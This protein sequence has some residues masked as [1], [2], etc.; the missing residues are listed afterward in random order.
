MSFRVPVILLTVGAGAKW[1][2]GGNLLRLE[3]GRETGADLARQ[4]LRAQQQPKLGLTAHG[5]AQL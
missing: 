4:P 3:D 1:P 5:I 2:Q